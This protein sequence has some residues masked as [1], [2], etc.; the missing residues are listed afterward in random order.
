[1]KRIVGSVVDSHA[2]VV[3]ISGMGVLRGGLWKILSPF[4]SFRVERKE[5]VVLNSLPRACIG[6][7][8]CCSSIVGSKRR[9]FGTSAGSAFYLGIEDRNVP[10]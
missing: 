5:I 1:V 2:A 7:L 3:R 6:N 8:R 10:L 4:V 9:F